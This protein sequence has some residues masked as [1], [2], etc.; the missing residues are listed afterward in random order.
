M[1]SARLFLLAVFTMFIVTSCSGICNDDFSGSSMQA[2]DKDT[3]PVAAPGDILKDVNFGFDRYDLVPDARNILKSH[4]EWLKA[5]PNRNVVI[6][7]HCDERGTVEYNLALGERRARA[8]YDYLRSL[9]VNSKQMSTVS[10][11]KEFPLD[12]RSNEEAWARNRR[13]HFALK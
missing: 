12:P 3:V 13:V 11:G 10:Y 5:N 1:Q 4:A 6:E 7:G 2:P 8:V 9:G